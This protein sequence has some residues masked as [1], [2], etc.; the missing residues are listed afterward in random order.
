MAF[1]VHLL[2][3]AHPAVDLQR[4]VGH[5]VG[6]FAGVELRHRGLARVA[7]PLVLHR[8]SAEREQTRRLQLGR[9]V[10]EHELDGLVLRDGHVEGLAQLRVIARLLEGG[11]ADADGLR[12]DADAP[13]VQGAHGDL[14]SVAL[15]A[16]ALPGRHLQ[17]VEEDGAAGRGADAE[18]L[19]GLLPDEAGRVGVDDECGDALRAF[20]QVRHGEHDDGV[21]DRA[22][23]DPILGA[24]DEVAIALAHRR[25]PLLGGIRPRLRFGQAE[26]A[27]LLSSRERLEPALFLLVVAVLEHRIAEERIVHAEGDADGSAA[28]RDLLDGQGIGD[29]VHPRA[30]PLRRH[31][32]SAETEL[33][34]LADRLGR[35][36]VLAIPALGVGPQFLFRELPAG[37][38][39]QPL[40]FGEFD[41][42]GANLARL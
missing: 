7:Q 38:A 30:A 21:G 37:V 13:A 2:R 19:V 24:V 8:C 10:R 4:L 28:A 33:E 1:H 18:L 3:V 40:L 16:E 35:E 36:P 27:D 12:G 11:P 26:A 15:G 17:V 42:H 23:G 25:R 6:R 34:G 29:G 32:D 22:V 20:A 5:A 31:R 9:H 14:E 41:L 39:Q